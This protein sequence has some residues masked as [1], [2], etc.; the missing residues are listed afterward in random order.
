[1][2]SNFE[3]PMRFDAFMHFALYHPQHG[4]YARG[5]GIFG[6]AGDF[7][8][9]PELSP[10][11][12]QTLGG[13]LASVLP[14]CPPVVT[15]FG[16]GSGQ[17]ACDVLLE[18]GHVLQAYQIV[19]VSGGLQ[20]AQRERMSKQLP[21]ALLNKV[22]WLSALPPRIEGLLIG[23]EV[24]DATPVRRFRWYS[25]GVD[26]AWVGLDGDHLALRWHAAD[27]AFTDRVNALQLAHGPWPEG[28]V[29]EF[30]EQAPALVRTLTERLYG[31][32]LMIDYGHDADHYYA[33]HRHQG[34]LRATLRHIAHD[35]FLNHV[36]EQDLTAHVDFSAVYQALCSCEGQ[37][38]GY[39]TQGEFLMAHGLLDRAA[40]TTDWN[41]PVRGGPQRQAVNTLLSEAHMGQEFKVLAWSKGVDLEGTALNHVFLR[42]DHSGKL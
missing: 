31:L 33:A 17:L 21:P 37:L 35:D 4:Y 30:N 5:Q 24:L 18:I 29:S 41:D 22:T 25:S 9:A 7:V 40:L 6:A 27:P 19:E 38:E 15:E 1:M 3:A 23:N 28:Y 12:G 20:H 2:L 8:T 36:G 39:T 32:A 42:H 14:R 13:A 16:A 34:T 10:L 11:F 26:E